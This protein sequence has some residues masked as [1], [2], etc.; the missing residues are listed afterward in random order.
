MTQASSL[1][2]CHCITESIKSLK[3]EQYENEESLSE[4]ASQKYKHLSTIV[5][6]STAIFSHNFPARFNVLV[7][8]VTK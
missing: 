4:H 2:Q 7:T 5:M 8:S 3:T 6:D 1:Y